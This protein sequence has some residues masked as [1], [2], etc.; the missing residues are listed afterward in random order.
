MT[1]KRRLT[2]IVILVLAITTAGFAWLLVHTARTELMRQLS[3]AVVGAAAKDA[4]FPLNPGPGGP[5][6]RP[7]RVKQTDLGVTGG[8]R[9]ARLLFDAKGQ[10]L[11]YEA[12]GFADEPDPV[13]GLPIIGSA[14][15]QAMI[16]ELV[17]RKSADG[18]IRYLVMTRPVR[19]GRVRFD[20]VSMQSADNAVRRLTL[21][22][23]LSGALAAAGASV[24]TAL[25]IRRSLRPVEEMVT[26]SERIASGDLAA[27]VP[28]QAGTT[29][30]GRL[31]GALNVMLATIEHALSQRDE[32]ELE[33]RRFIADA[34]HELR[35]PVTVIQGYNDLYR[36]GA[37]AEPMKLDKAM[38]RIGFQTERMARLV[39]DLLLLANLDRPEF[40][41]RSKADLAS[42]AA[43]AVSDFALVAPEYPATLRSAGPLLAEV[44]A[45]RIRQV[46]DNLLQNIRTHTTVGT[47]VVVEVVQDIHNVRLVIHNSGAGIKP[48]DLGRLFER[49][50]RAE[51]DRSA[52]SSGL[53]LAIVESIVTA[54]DGTISVQSNDVDGTTFTI[55]LPTILR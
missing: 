34:S 45:Q 18:S 12:S 27:R 17:V 39:K 26:T 35:T 11:N 41:V 6:S 20:A 42:I 29:E 19:N 22:A 14:E 38:D 2:T 47:A 46:F 55:T 49:F 13:V 8:R 36:S 32:K 23:V 1:L 50:F 40:I 5:T 37:L 10:L 4:P 33:L 31:G 54:H 9:V 21:A 53:G 25:S 30:L 7:K 48:T 51:G 3:D 15:Q 24:I 16:D 52:D 28:L 43:E 44:D